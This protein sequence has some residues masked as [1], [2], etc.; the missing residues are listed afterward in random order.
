VPLKKQAHSLTQEQEMEL[1]RESFKDF[2]LVEEDMKK[3][4]STLVKELW[5]VEGKD[6]HYKP[7]IQRTNFR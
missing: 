4:V 1:L 3:S 5:T 2:T 7:P 6:P